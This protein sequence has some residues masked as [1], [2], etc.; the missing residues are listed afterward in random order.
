M[1]RGP[2]ADAQPQRRSCRHITHA[3]TRAGDFEHL[4]DR[5]QA[6]ASKGVQGRGA[7]KA[8]PRLKRQ[9]GWDMNSQAISPRR[10][11]C[12][13]GASVV[14]CA[15]VIITTRGGRAA[16]AFRP[17]TGLRAGAAGVPRCAPMCWQG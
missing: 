7:S 3:A 4:D 5:R 1:C 15:G 2:T 16:G 9:A 17:S 13:F 8:L 10:F 6:A 12:R 11:V 14:S